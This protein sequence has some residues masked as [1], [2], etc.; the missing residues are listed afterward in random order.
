MPQSPDQNCQESAGGCCKVLVKDHG[1]ASSRRAAGSLAA[2][3][4]FD[5]NLACGT[6]HFAVCEAMSLG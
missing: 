6:G 2:W 5:L 4:G 1:N 3:N